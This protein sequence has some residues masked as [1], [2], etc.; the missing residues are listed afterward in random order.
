VVGG[1]L[2]PPQKFIP[3]TNKLETDRK[4]V[5]EEV[6]EDNNRCMQHHLFTISD[7]SKTGLLQE[8]LKKKGLNPL[9]AGC[10]VLGSRILW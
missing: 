8:F 6:Q 3:E 7:E 1:D 9:L 10:M 2:F 4:K 5:K